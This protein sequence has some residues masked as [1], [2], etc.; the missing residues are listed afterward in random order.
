MST[1]VVHAGRARDPSTGAVVPPIQLST[2]FE[3][4]DQG[5]LRG[6]YLYSRIANPNREAL[7]RCLMDLEEAGAALCFASGSAAAHALLQA[8]DPGDRVIYSD[9]LYH[10]T[11]K[12]MAQMARTGIRFDEVDLTDLPAVERALDR[13]ARLVFCESPTNPL[14]RVVD[15]TR[16]AALARERGALVVVDNTWATP[17]LQRPLT[18]GCDLVLH[19]TTKY[20]AGHSDVTG[21]ALCTRDPT[22][23]LWMRIAELQRLGGAVPSPFDCWLALRGIATLAV[24]MRAHC[25]NAEELAGWLAG[26]PAVEAVHYPGLPDDPG[27]EVARRQMARPGGMLSFLV[28]GGLPAARRFMA[29]LELLHRAT[30]LG[31]VHTLVEHR[32]PV[33]GPDTRT[34]QNLIRLSVGIEDVEDIRADLDQALA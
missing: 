34:P 3:R 13:P 4:D 19:A 17:V 23:P 7:E 1:R 11:R 14:L 29:R 22:H 6:P 16:L 32:A 28:K 20:L 21:G 12:L 5:E 26:H 15:L 24:R 33:E 10:G 9:D 27:A 31:G 8:L 30:S 18:L 2:T 25:D